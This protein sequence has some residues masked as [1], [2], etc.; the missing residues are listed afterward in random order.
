MPL[1]PGAHPRILIELA[2]ASREDPVGRKLLICPRPAEG[3]ELLHALALAGVPWAGWEATSI[4]QLAHDVVA[5]DA[6]REGWRT[7]DDFDVLALVDDAIDAV[8]ERGEAGPFGTEAGAGYRDAIR[9]SIET[10]REA[11]LGP[12]EVRRAARPGDTKTAALAA[13]LEEVESRFE[14][15]RLLDRPALLRAAVDA[16]A[17]ERVALPSAALFLLPGHRLGGVAGRFLRLLVEKGGARL[18]PTDSVIGLEDPPGILW[19][20]P[21]EA[22]GPLSRL[23]AP[24]DG[25]RGPGVELF[26]AAT[27]TDE[28]REVLRRAISAGIPWDRI[29]IVACDARVYGAALDALARRLD[30]PVTYAAGLDVRRTRVG[31]AAEAYLRWISEGFPAEVLRRMLEAGDLAAPDDAADVSGMALAR[32]LRRLHI[33]WGRERYLPAVDRALAGLRD[34]RVVDEDGDDDAARE[35]RSREERELRALRALLGGIVSATPALPAR[36]G[37]DRA[38]TSPAA[39][40]AGLLA[41]LSWVPTGDVVEN[42]ARRVLTSR[43]ER[44]RETLT[45]ETAWRAAVGILRSRIETSV[46]PSAVDGRLVPW[47]PTGGHLHLSDLTTGGLAGRPHVFVVGLAAG[48]VS[49]GGVDPLLAEG[50][51][52]RL[53]RESGAEVAP[54][55]L[56]A[57]R[58]AESRHRLAAMLARLRG[59]VTLSYSAW[60]ATEGR[61]IAPAPELLQALRLREGDSSLAYEDL[62]ARLGGLVGAV[63]RGDAHAEPADVW[64]RALATSD[65]GLRSGVAVVR[66]AHPGLDRGLIAVAERNGKEATAFDGKID[67]RPELHPR[68]GDAVFSPSR[69]EALGTC[70]RRYFFRYVLGVRAV[71]DPEWDPESWLDPLDRG[72]LLH[73]VYERT[74]AEAR[75]EGIEPDDDGFEPLALR[76]LAQEAERA[77]ARR[78]APNDAVLAAERADLEADVR[79]FVDMIRRSRPDWVE[80]ELAFGPGDREVEVVLPGGPVR[81]AGRV[82]RVDRSPTGALRIVDYKTGSA[83]RYRASRPFEGGRR[84]QHILYSLAVERLL[85]APVEAMEYHFPT[86]HGRNE[87]VVYPRPA[88][89]DGPAVIETLLGIA[90]DGHFLPTDDV[91]DCRY[92]DYQA[93]CRARTDDYGKTVCPGAAWAKSAS[94]E[95]VL[96]YARLKTLREHHA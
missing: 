13:V 14:R 30:I 47:T 53:N 20:A 52:A 92:C 93:V 59:R 83:S 84:L 22:T 15:R 31:R 96:E 85:D 67:P 38:R 72:T 76:V 49:G 42:T 11:G 94:A 57:E 90:A 70:P 89:A 80:L 81:L 4:R 73:A 10:L 69:L 24:V 48:I 41:F 7:A 71:R 62:R 26:A 1:D 17:A 87:R 66:A 35:A 60:D 46:S 27:P 91:G 6:A 64:L 18:L 68:H 3:R 63:P 77:L 56:A 25:E 74:L 65:G 39:V 79:A 23:H 82:D 2:K 51:R 5:L 40:A 88:I 43:L 78:P 95:D 19:R 32:R 45:R 50:D 44:A 21:K 54:L 16:L 29:E 12:A 8:V 34:A 58:V 9:R 61:A 33:G 55:P 75:A 28:L 37:D 86:V 36:A